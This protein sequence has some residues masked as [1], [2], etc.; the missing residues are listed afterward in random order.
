MFPLIST[1]I[2]LLISAFIWQQYIRRRKPYQCV[3]ASA[4]TLFAAACGAQW[5]AEAWGWSPFLARV[6]Y[7]C[8]AILTTGYLALG[9]IWLLR[10]GRVARLLTLFVVVLSIVATVTLWQ[11]PVD[12]S[13][14]AEIGW[15][16]LARPQVTRSISLLFNIGGTLLLA[17]GTIAS[18]WGMRGKRHLR[19]RAAGLGILTLGV[20]VVA[21]GGSMVGVLGLS[22]PDTL[23]TTNSIGAGIIL[24]GIWL[25]DRPAPS[26]LRDQA[27][28][29]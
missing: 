22:E 24:A 9:L 21:A 8:G 3:W 25:A 20:L 17:G 29:F 5:V 4:F 16:A 11:A 1:L 19:N 6:F 7:L 2:S 14:M 27:R 15:Q 13:A 12:A 18:A 23:A 10:P 26:T 28:T